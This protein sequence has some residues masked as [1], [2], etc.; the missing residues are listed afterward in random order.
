MTLMAPEESPNPLKLRAFKNQRAANN[1][2]ITKTKL[3]IAGRKSKLS[4]FLGRLYTIQ[5]S[6]NL[7]NRDAIFPF[8]SFNHLSFCDDRIVYLNVHKLTRRAI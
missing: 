1:K 4:N 6:N 3:R 2:P 5:W 7:N 8:G